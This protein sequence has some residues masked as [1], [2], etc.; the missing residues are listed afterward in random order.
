MASAKIDKAYLEYIRAKTAAGVS[1]DDI[2]RVLRGNG[3]SDDDIA[4]AFAA[5]AASSVGPGSAASGPTGGAVQESA[6]ASPSPSAPEAVPAPAFSHTPSSSVS[7]PVYRNVTPRGVSLAQPPHASRKTFGQHIEDVV[8]SLVAIYQLGFGLIAIV[9]MV[10]TM[11]PT[12]STIASEMSL[13]SQQNVQIYLGLNGATLL[14]CLLNVVAGIRL[15]KGRGRRLSSLL[16]VLQ[17][18]ALIMSGAQYVLCLGLGAVASLSFPVP[19][20]QFHLAFFGGPQFILS[21]TQ[22]AGITVGINLSAILLIIALFFLK[23]PN[24][25]ARV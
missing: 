2:A 13:L 25:R 6:S 12:L 19:P 7:V 5:A 14:F 15:L 18:P 3:V 24:R 16:A 20:Y 10:R 17:M 23:N 11:A 4:E 22:A 1:T 21:F 8:R 9:L